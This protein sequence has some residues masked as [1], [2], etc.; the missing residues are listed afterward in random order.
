MAWA[1]GP[2]LPHVLRQET[3][4]YGASSPSYVVAVQSLRHVWLCDPIDHS[5]PG[6]SVFQCLP[7]FAQIHVHWVSDAIQPSHSLSPPSPPALNLSQHQGLF[8]WVS[9]LPQMAKILEIQLQLPAVKWDSDFCH[10]CETGGCKEDPDSIANIDG[11]LSVC[12]AL[13]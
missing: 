4:F 13:V 10:V 2:A 11:V 3:W 7:E 12:S 9:S 1:W 8:Q 6:S 5:T